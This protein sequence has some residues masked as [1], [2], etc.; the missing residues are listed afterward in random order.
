MQYGATLHTSNY[1]INVLNEMFEDKLIDKSQT[2]TC[3]VSRLKSLLS[4]ICEET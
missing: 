3:K 4:S 1:S 2:V